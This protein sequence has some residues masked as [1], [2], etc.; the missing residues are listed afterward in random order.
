MLSEDQKK[1]LAQGK[2]NIPVEAPQSSKSKIMPQKVPNKPKKPPN[3]NQ[4]G[5]KKAKPKW[6]K[7]YPQNYRIPKKE[8]TAMDNVFDMARTLMELKNTEE[9]ILSQYFPKKLQLK[10]DIKLIINNISPKKDLPRQS[11]PILDRNVL[12]LNDD[13]HHTISSNAEVGTACNFKDIPRLEEWST[14]SGEGEYDN[15]EFMKT[16]DIFKE[17]FN[18]QD[19][20]IS[21]RL[22]SLFT[23]SAKKWYYKMGQDHDKHSWPWW[24]EQIIY[25]W[26]NDSWRFKMENS[27]E[28][29][30]FNIERDRPMS[31]FLKK[32]DG[33]TSLHPNM[34]ETIV[35]KRILRECGGDLENAI[36]SRCIDPCSTE[37]YINAMEDITTRTKNCRNWYKPSMDNKTSGKPIPKPNKPHD[38]APLKC[39]KC[40]STSHLANTCP[41][42]PRINEIEIEKYDKKETNNVS[43]HESDSEPSEEEELPDELSIENIIVSFEV[44]EVHTHLPQYS[45]ECMDLIHVQDAK[46]QKN[47]SARGKGYTAGSSCITH[48]VINNREAKIHLDSG[49]FHTCVVK[50]YLDKIYTPWQD[51]L[52][53][54]EGIKFSSSSQNMYPLGIF[55]AGMIFPHPTG[56]IRLKV[57]FVVMNNCTS[58]NFIP[59]N[60]YL[61]I[62]GIGINNHKDRYFTIG[63]NKRQKFAFPPRKREITFIRQVKNVKKEIFVLDQSIEEQISP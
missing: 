15:M 53:P 7:P 22:H 55:E 25:K 21:S 8:K 30:T 31:L 2:E 58:K 6:N 4:N 1:K 29:A 27:F 24:K 54:I 39:H 10:E 11:T 36:R 26:D 51:R 46:M 17:D 37:D 23:E 43:A 45:D 28:E 44:K 42:K 3:T 52:M 13:L 50:D 34:S 12:N 38:K 19:E 60:N 56:S 35:D 62:Y 48:T 63:E 41:K 5:K 9:E 59:R 18:I 33:L 32:K 47:K 57:E 20:Y 61:N 40:G 49:A 16:I 14:F